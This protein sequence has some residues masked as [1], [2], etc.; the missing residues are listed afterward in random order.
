MYYLWTFNRIQ[1]TCSN[2]W[3]TML[4]ILKYIFYIPINTAEHYSKRLL[5]LILRSGLAI[6][7][8]VTL[9]LSPCP[10]KHFH[11]TRPYSRMPTIS[12][13]LCWFHVNFF[14]FIES[15]IPQYQSGKTS[16][17]TLISNSLLDV[18]LFLQLKL[19]SLSL[20]CH[21]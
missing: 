5:W 10:N 18:I 12:N 20:V 9:A 1:T 17:N 19:F 2:L 11:A 16:R 8:T 4:Y 3:F 7:Y 21:V 14:I 6:N 15:S 13:Q